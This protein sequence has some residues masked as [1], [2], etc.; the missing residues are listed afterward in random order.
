MIVSFYL[1]I[2]DIFLKSEG[3]GE[4]KPLYGSPNIEIKKAGIAFFFGPRY[5]HWVCDHIFIDHFNRWSLKPI[6]YYLYYILAYLIF[7]MQNNLSFLLST[8]LIKYSVHWEI[9]H[10]ASRS[11]PCK[12]LDWS[13]H[14]EN[15]GWVEEFFSIKHHY[16]RT[17]M[18]TE[19][20][21]S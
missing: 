16:V 2:F 17:K 10:S 9:H 11:H 15:G 13:C 5:T 3:F 18:R 20:I 12:K 6:A 8:A 21:W 4:L 14:C 7:L 19:A 1:K